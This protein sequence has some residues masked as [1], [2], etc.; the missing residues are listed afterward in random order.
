MLP[1][2]LFINPYRGDPANLKIY[3]TTFASNNKWIPLTVT[4][5]TT[6]MQIHNFTAKLERKSSCTSP[7]PKENDVKTRLYVK[8][9]FLL[10]KTNETFELYYFC[11]SMKF[12]HAGD[13][14]CNSSMLFCFLLT[15]F[16]E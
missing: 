3:L 4:T 15:A 5:M 10:L 2:F 1:V 13:F 14:Q 16:L 6:E 11:F 9:Y 8:V 12:Q 7:C